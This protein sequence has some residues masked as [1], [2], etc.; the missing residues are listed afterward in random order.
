MLA[1]VVTLR[2]D[3]VIEA[4]DDAPLQDF[5]KA[6]E[7]FAIR[8]HFFV[9]NE[10]PY[11]AVLVTYGLRPTPVQAASDEK[12][13]GSRASWR[14]PIPEADLP[15]WNALRTW[16]GERAQREGVPPYVIC[17]NR[18]LAAMGAPFLGFRVFPRVVRLDGRKLARL[19]RRVRGREA[20]CRAGGM[21]E[22]VLARSV[23]SMK[24]P[25]V[26]S[27][28]QRSRQ[29]QQQPGLSP[30]EHTM[31]PEGAVQGPRPRASAVSRRF[32]P[33]RRSAGQ[34][35]TACGVW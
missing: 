5:L 29:S 3:P 15:L 28:Q 14:P 12:T 16:R 20:I 10:V 22:D 9:R 24:R 32:I 21:D 7:V 18:Q 13:K 31:E 33:R 1:R 8:E 17:S 2:F 26:E 35:T 23:Q 4:F 34:T 25:R 30:A 27:R 6:K 19:R 11:L